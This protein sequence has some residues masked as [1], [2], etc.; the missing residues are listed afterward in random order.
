MAGVTLEPAPTAQ[1]ARTGPARVLGRLPRSV[2]PMQIATILAI[3]ALAYL[4][5]VPLIATV[6]SA[7]RGP[8]ETLPFAEGSY[9]TFENFFAIYRSGALRTTLLDTAIY[10]GGAV[11]IALAI[12]FSLAWVIERTDVPG[13][14]WLF[15][16]ALAPLLLPPI[17]LSQSWL[18]MVSSKT[19]FLNVVIRTFLPFFERGPIDAFSV[20]GMILVQGV[21]FVPFFTILLT[22]VFRNMDGGLEEAAR[23][24]GAGFVATFL[25]VSLPL[26]KPGVLS[27]ALLGAIIIM[28]SFEV[29]LLFGVGSGSDVISLRLWNS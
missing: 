16:L 9:Q 25:R 15:V 21:L 13:R 3:V 27:V 4:L 18:L 6:L 17:I 20:P 10:V 2:S 5:L 11:A 12:G 14:N 22:S 28:G 24:S 26:L 29:P 23:V 19:G 8:L 7:F 1:A